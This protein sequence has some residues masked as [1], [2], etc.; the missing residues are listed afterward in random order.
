MSSLLVCLVCGFHC[1]KVPTQ[2]PD[3]LVKDMDDEGYTLDSE[4]YEDNRLAVWMM[5]TK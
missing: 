2:N 5:D 1:S 4:I 3:P